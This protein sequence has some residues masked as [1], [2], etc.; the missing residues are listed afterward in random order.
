MSPK[1]TVRYIYWDSCVFLSYVSRIPERIAVL[2]NILD[3]AQKK[4]DIKIISSALAIAEVVFA[5][6]HGPGRRMPAP[7]EELIDQLWKASFV[8]LVEASPILFME[9]RQ[10]MRQAADDGYSLK[11]LD[12]VHLATATWFDGQITPLDEVHTYDPKWAKFGAELNLF[13]CEPR[14]LQPPLPLADSGEEGD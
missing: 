8:E 3:E 2:E 6:G 4:S 5:S 12:A 1:K 14:L 7:Q 10:L 13:I 11:V 9:A